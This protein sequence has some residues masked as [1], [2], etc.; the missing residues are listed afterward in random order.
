MAHFHLCIY[1][2]HSHVQGL[3]T[4]R[5]HYPSWQIRLHCG[6]SGGD[7]GVRSAVI[8]E[9]KSA[10]GAEITVCL[11]QE[12]VLNNMFS[13]FSKKNNRKYQKSLSEKSI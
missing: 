10:M 7:R 8:T 1:E 4:C 2:Y 12:N 9:L 11:Y 13:T 5:K 6:S 3:K